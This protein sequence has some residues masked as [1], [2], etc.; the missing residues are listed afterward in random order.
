MTEVS[1]LATAMAGG[2]KGRLTASGIAGWGA[3]R[4]GLRR[5]V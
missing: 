3:M 2:L 5:T 1:V 4:R